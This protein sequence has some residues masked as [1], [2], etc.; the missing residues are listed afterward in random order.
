MALQEVSARAGNEETSPSCTVKYDF[1]DSL[2]EAVELFGADAVYARFKSASIVDLQALIRRHL[3][4]ETPKSADEIQAL[5]TA[6]KPGVQ[7]RKRKSVGEKI[8]ELLKDMSPADR[9]AA[10]AQ[11]Q[12]TAG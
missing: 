10:L 6:W 9:A 2:D 12:S 11:L 4:G 1:G 7:T 8:E 5:A 3:E